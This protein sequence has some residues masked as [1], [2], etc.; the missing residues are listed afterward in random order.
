LR[1]GDLALIPGQPFRQQK[2]DASAQGRTEAV[3]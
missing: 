2:A 1:Y 3:D